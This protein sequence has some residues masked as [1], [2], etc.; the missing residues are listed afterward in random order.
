VR[1]VRRLP[2]GGLRL[3]LSPEEAA[4]L[5]SLPGQLR[6]IV[7]GDAPGDLA[8][9]IRSRFFPAAYDDPEL[10]DEYRS[11]AS[12]ELVRGRIDALDTFERTLAEVGPATRGKVRLDLDADEAAAWLAVVNDTRLALASV[13]GI[14]SESQWEDGPDPRVTPTRWCRAA[15]R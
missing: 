10:D 13:L 14:T 1:S 2:E 8:E 9:V 7:E 4:A 11:L 3:T 6:P 5:S 15:W 12:E